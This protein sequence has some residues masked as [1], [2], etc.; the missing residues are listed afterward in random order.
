MKTKP[1]KLKKIPKFKTENAERA[2]WGKNDVIDYFDTSK[3][4]R[5][6]LT[7]LKPSTQTISLRL[8]LGLLE[9]IKMMAN[10]ND[11]PYQSLM[12]MLLADAVKREM[13]GA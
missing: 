12:K 6:A 4:M 10:T 3:V 8:P 13:R 1:S 2:F 11:V 7:K 9:K 5:G